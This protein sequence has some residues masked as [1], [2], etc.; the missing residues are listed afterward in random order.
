MLLRVVAMNHGS[1]T[2]LRYATLF[3]E[4]KRATV[5]AFVTRSG[6]M[7]VQPVPSDTDLNVSKSGI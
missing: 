2:G 3:E 4:R 5:F 6:G 7:G 1:V